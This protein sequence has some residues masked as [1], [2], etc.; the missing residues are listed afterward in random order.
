MKS[1]TSLY[2]HILKDINPNA[3]QK[4]CAVCGKTFIA[5]NPKEYAYKKQGKDNQRMKY[6]CSWSHLRQWEQKN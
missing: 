4:T 3:F 6:F 2:D 5:I 1:K